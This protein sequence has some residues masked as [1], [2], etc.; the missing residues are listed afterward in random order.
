MGR[1][2]TSRRQVH[3][4]TRHAQVNGERQIWLLEN[5]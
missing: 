4:V 2:A 5:D 1:S 3:T